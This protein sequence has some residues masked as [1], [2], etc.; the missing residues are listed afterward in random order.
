MID[1]TT[2]DIEI[3]GEPRVGIRLTAYPHPHLIVLGRVS[4]DFD[5]IDEHLLMSYTYDMIEG[6]DSD[7]LRIAVGDFIVQYCQNS[8]TEKVF[9][10]GT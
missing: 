1:Y 7:A 8:E 5:K 3:N 10:N 9:T 2:T 6:S 4:F